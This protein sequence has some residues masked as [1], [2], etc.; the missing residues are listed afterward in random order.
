[1]ISTKN[2]VFFLTCTSVLCCCAFCNGFDTNDISQKIYMFTNF[3]ISS[4]VCT[5]YIGAFFIHKN[6]WSCSLPQFWNL[7]MKKNQKYT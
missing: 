1:M 6:P 5:L 3:S 7:M 2:M 4:F